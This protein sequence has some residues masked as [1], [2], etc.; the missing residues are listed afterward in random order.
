MARKLGPLTSIPGVGLTTAIVV[1]AKTNGFVLVENERQLA[2]Y[3]GL[4]MVQ[5][6]SGLSA[7]AMRISRWGNVRLRTALYLPASRQ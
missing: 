5:H 1:V 4:D 6:Q 7:R 2:S 3:A